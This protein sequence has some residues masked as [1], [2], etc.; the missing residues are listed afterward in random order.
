M[1]GGHNADALQLLE[2]D[3]RLVE[4][5]ADRYLALSAN[6][7]RS[8]RGRWLADEI[9]LVLTIHTR[10]VQ[11]LVHP[12]AR[13]A[14]EDDEVVD[15]NDAEHERTRELVGKLFAARGDD[16]LRDAKVAVLHDA[17]LS[18]V[19]HEREQ[20]F[21]RLRESPLDLRALARSMALRKE[22]LKGVADALRE[23]VLAAS[24]TA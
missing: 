6:E 12:A 13:S 5:L 15:D 1:A 7:A 9:C 18:L 16:P 4:S 21:P 22:E 14:L 17:F 10:L 2:A 11:E 19:R 3:H 20:L 24:L 8:T 23:E